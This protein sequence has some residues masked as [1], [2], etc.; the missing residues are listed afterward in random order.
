MKKKKKKKS[1]KSKKVNK[2]K[3]KK[4]K[5]GICRDYLDENGNIIDKREKKWL[6]VNFRIK[7]YF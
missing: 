2:S 6:Y 4:N 5:C 7:Y 1:S 3:E